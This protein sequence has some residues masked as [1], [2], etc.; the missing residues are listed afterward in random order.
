MIAH[1]NTL[2]FLL[3]V[4]IGFLLLSQNLQA[5]P[6]QICLQ[7]KIV[8]SGGTPLTGDRVYRIRFFDAESVGFQIGSD[9]TGSTLVSDTGRFE[10]RLVPP[11]GVFA[12]NEVFY[13]IAIDSANPPDG[14]IDVDDVFPNRVKIV[15]TLF[16]RLSA[17]SL[18][19]RR[20]RRIRFLATAR[21]CRHGSRCALSW[22][23]GFQRSRALCQ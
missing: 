16:S 20:K 21:Q 4:S 2:W 23:T 7:G 9:F 1:G 13:E 8:D 19:S 12:V 3:A 17:D 22:D 11:V 14:T 18:K 5:V 15:S 6:E 10:I